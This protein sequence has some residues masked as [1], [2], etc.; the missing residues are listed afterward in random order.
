MKNN[1]ITFRAQNEH[2]WEVREKPISA[3][4]LIPD[5]W[6]NMA[7]YSNKENKLKLSPQSTVTVK[8]CAPSMDALISG[9]IVT[10]WADIMVTQTGGFPQIQWT[11]SENVLELWPE[12]QVGGF[13]I[14]DGYDR[15]VYKYMHGWTIKTPPGWSCLI[16]HPFGYSNI[17]IKTIPG[18]V[19]T[20]VL[21]TEINT[22][23]FI[24]KGFEGIIEKGTPM[25]QIIPIKRD[26]WESEF[27]LE[28]P[29]Q[30]FFN[31][32]KLKTKISS[33]YARNLR[34]T[35]KYEDGKI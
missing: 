3:S 18:V 20:D 15:F 5:W 4:K 24:K 8:K 2:V 1:K 31:V 22:P 9:Y 6:K 11:T 25:F 13:E 35:K 10:L 23:F 26:H 32:E 30:H 27:V 12:E 28:K 33:S 19:D 21:E 17:P 34:H 14:P 29:N 7:P 16:A